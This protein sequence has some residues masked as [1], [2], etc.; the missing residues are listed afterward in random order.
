MKDRTIRLF[1][2]ADGASFGLMPVPVDQ[3]PGDYKVELLDKGGAAVET[4]SIQVVGAH[5][6]KQNVVIEQS[7]A[8]LKPSPGETEAVTAFR[9]AVS[10][11]RYWSEPF[12]L[13]VRG[14]ITSPFG[15][16]RYM[17]GQPTGN[18]HGGLDQRS[19]AGTPVHAV[20]GGV[21]KI[22]REWNLHGRTVG[23]DHG[24][25]L[26]SIYLHMSKLA[27]TEGARVKKGEV[28]GYVGSTGRSTA[29]HLHWSLYVNRV[30]V[31]P[32]DWVQVAP[33][34]SAKKA[35]KKGQHLGSR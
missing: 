28:V 33:C 26:E 5:F 12:A 13:P 32:L 1:P 30:S 29:P 27:A 2:Q 14:C 31:N 34:S 19:P 4:A 6:R 18:F 17:N 9:N 8:E 25:G 3:R 10:E 23:I 21:V 24:Q 35:T 11:V 7:L 20:D 22:A 15:V 16:Q